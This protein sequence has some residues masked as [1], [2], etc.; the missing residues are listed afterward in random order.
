MASL[1]ARARA[2]WNHPAGPQTIF[3]WAPTFKWGLIAANIADMKK[4][5]STVSIPQQ[6]AVAGTG[7]IWVRYSTQ[8]IPVNY[9]LM[10][11]N[12]WMVGTGGYQLFRKLSW[13][14][15]HKEGFFAEA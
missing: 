9:N 8:I 13:D 1:G 2:F 7:A 5:A 11:V 4:P 12:M 10:L 6:T 3:F 15:E 14:R